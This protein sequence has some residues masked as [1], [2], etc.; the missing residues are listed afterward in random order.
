MRIGVHD[1]G[2]G[3]PPAAM[4]KVFEPFFRLDPARG[5]APHGRPKAAT[6]GS[7]PAGTTGNGEPVG[8]GLG[9]SIARNVIL[10]HGGEIA[11]I[12]RTAGGLRVLITL[13]RSL[14]A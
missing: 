3:I 8:S 12:N 7:I 4:D 9:L 10:A 6:D 11:L 14:P 2:P 13:P 5:A 1:N